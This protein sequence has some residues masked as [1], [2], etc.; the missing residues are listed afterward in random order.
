MSD[1]IDHTASRGAAVLAAVCVAAVILPLSFS[2]G[3]IATPAIGRALGGGPVAL[4]WITNAFMLAFGS[5]LMAAGTLADRFGRRRVFLCGV[6]VFSLMSMLLALAPGIV[7]VDLL[8]AAQGVGAAAALA[9]GSAALAQEFDGHA[10]T[11]AFSLLGT[12][13][14]VGLAFGP[15]L[16]GGLIELFGWRAV[17]VSTALLGAMSLLL[18]APGMPETRDPHASGV[19]W[20]GMASFTAALGLF[21]VAILEA[22]D[23]GWGHPAVGSLL[24]VAAGSLVAFVL[25]ERHT[26][27]PM[28]DLSLFRYRRFVGVQLLP[29]A[30][31]YCFVV[32]LVILPI[33]FVG[34]EGYAP[35]NAGLMMI[36]L[37]APMLVMPALAVRLT[38]HASPGLISSLGLL[39]AAAGLVW[40]GGVPVGAE[41]AALLVPMGVIGIGTGLPWGLMDGLSVSVVPKERAGMATGIF[42]TTRVAGEGLALAMVSAALAGIVAARLTPVVAALAPLAPGHKLM[43]AGGGAPRTAID[44]AAQRL[45]TGDLSGAS[46]LLPGV[47][48]AML[49][50]HYADAFHLLTYGLAAIT[51]LAALATLRY[52]GL[53]DRQG[54]SVATTAATAT[55]ATCDDAR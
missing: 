2:A 9:G 11:R 52:L 34:I 47:S 40:L 6:S 36:A 39:I 22:P 35:L 19:D 49:R 15:V 51:V 28:L 7:W 26:A 20:P 37:S 16:A 46:T 48:L 43:A 10:R 23:I 4:N 44:L 53:G 54:A 29:I 24:A 33:R 3:A 18:A 30:T 21:T 41:P 32:L 8:R 45:A 14:G 55:T 27:R 25:I 31:C 5:C 1:S 17:F 13:F 50:Q 42:S 38:R 12:T